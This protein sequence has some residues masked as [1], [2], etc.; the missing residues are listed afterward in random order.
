MTGLIT[1]T[2]LEVIGASLAGEALT[3]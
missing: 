3:G 2:G 1:K